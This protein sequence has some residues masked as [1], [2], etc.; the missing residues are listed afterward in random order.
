MTDLVV[1]WNTEY[2]DRTVAALRASGET[3]DD[4]LLGHISPALTE[5]V[6]FR[7]T[8]AFDVDRELAGLDPAGYRPLRTVPARNGARPL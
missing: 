5:H 7:G 4:E 3:I 1:A 8:Y 6:R 2:L